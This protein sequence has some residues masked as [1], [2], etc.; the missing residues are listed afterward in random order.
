MPND[1]NEIL[2]QI[3]PAL[4]TKYIARLIELGLRPATARKQVQRATGGYHKLAG[5]RFEKNTRFIYR[6]ED[7]DT[8]AF[9]RNLEAAFYTHG[10]SYWGAVVNLRARGGICRKERFTQISGA[11]IL[12]KGQLSPDVILERLKAVNVLDEIVDGEQAYTS[13]YAHNAP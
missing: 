6:P 5:L 1:V 10:K 12:R 8:P 4:T 2:R 7:Y 13:I 3:G 11:P 9:W